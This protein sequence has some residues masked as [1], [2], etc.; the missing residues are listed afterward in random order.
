MMKTFVV[1]K[2]VYLCYKI[3]LRKDEKSV[4]IA[5]KNFMITQSTLIRYKK[6]NE[7]AMDNKSISK[8]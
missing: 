8:N 2:N 1:G 4:F 7:Y 3:Q 5:K 6:I